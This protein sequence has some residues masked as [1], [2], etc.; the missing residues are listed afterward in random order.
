MNNHQ[1]S[2]FEQT[3]F[4][5]ILEYFLYQYGYIHGYIHSKHRFDIPYY[6]YRYQPLI[7][8]YFSRENL[9]T[10][11]TD[12]LSEGQKKRIQSIIFAI[13]SGKF[14]FKSYILAFDQRFEFLFQDGTDYILNPEYLSDTSLKYLQDLLQEPLETYLFFVYQAA[15]VYYFHNQHL[16]IDLYFQRCFRF[17]PENPFVLSRYGRYL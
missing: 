7:T 12:A 17:D 13:E 4:E 3:L 6:Y 10:T 15:M 16:D 9:V 8:V 11:N 14:D 1:T 5:S 2:F